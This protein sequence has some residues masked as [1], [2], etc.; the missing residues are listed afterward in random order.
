MFL[1]SRRVFTSPSLRST[2]SCRDRVG[3]TM[4][5]ELNLIEHLW[6]DL[7]EK[8]FHNRAFHSLG[9]LEDQ[10]ALALNTLELNPG[11]ISSIVSWPWIFAA[12]ITS[13]MN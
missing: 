2:A 12:L 8:F 13:F 10:L 9:A 6:D 11:R 7:R 5:T 1:L 3:C 4:P